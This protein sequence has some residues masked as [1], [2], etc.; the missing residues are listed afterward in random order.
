MIDNDPEQILAQG[1]EA[2]KAG[3]RPRARELLARAIRLNPADDRAWLWLSG[4]VE[5]DDD[6]RR[7]LERVL[8]L[9]PGN[10]AAQ[11]GLAAMA[12]AA[13]VAPAAVPPA[14]P[15]PARAAD[16]APPAVSVRPPDEP[17]PA[18]GL[19]LQPL[20]AVRRE[21]VAPTP[22]TEQ[23]APAEAQPAQHLPSEPDKGVLV[24]ADMAKLRSSMQPA[25]G[26]RIRPLVLVL[27]VVL[28][29]VV[30]LAVLLALGL[31]DVPGWVVLPFASATVA[32]AEPG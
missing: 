14:P 9:N 27:L 18:A 21:P 8:Q 26:R 15:T 25:S 31:I 12:P 11:R 23:P 13:S 6:R 3:D 28:V 24:M 22:D 16:P 1:I 17:A 2:V 20:A 5:T 4:A 30:V 7:C 19:R 10:Q 32:P 29:V